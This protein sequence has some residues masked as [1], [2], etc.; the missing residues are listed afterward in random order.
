MR[1]WQWPPGVDDQ[2]EIDGRIYTFTGHPAAPGIPYV[3]EGR[4]STVYQVRAAG[5]TIGPDGKRQQELCALKVFKQALYWKRALAGP[6]GGLQDFASLPGLQVCNRTVLSSERYL[7]VLKHP[8]LLFAVLMPWIE[9]QTWSRVVQTKQPITQGDSVMLARS[10]AEILNG[11]SARGAAHCDLSGDNLIVQGL[12]TSTS[13]PSQVALVDVEQLSAPGLVRPDFL[14][15]GSG[16]YAHRASGG[17]WD[18]TADRFAG[19]V[20]LAEMMAWC[21]PIT[22][23]AAWGDSYFAPD[24][25]HTPCARYELLRRAL[26]ERGEWAVAN[27]FERAWQS[28]SLA[29]CPTFQQWLN[30]L[31]RTADPGPLKQGVADTIRSTAPGT[32]GTRKSSGPDNAGDSKQPQ[33]RAQNAVKPAETG[34]PGAGQ[35]TAPG[36]PGVKRSCANI[37]ARIFWIMFLILI[38]LGLAFLGS[39]LL[40]WLGQQVSF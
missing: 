34:V 5:M 13:L 1:Q 10:L 22:R 31:P 9:G 2:I 26:V 7:M 14:P 24:E 4:Y 39:H 3:Q 8:N 37:L 16:G 15:Q 29:A 11:L 30:A 38:G 35:S 27:L 33:K 20:L 23:E 17:L 28:E 25:M 18:A 21:D 12:D 32:T 40:Y 6:A 36:A 19:A